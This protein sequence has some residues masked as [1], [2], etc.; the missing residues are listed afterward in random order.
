MDFLLL[1]RV[2][3]RLFF[4]NPR[5]NFEENTILSYTP[6]FRIYLL[7]SKNTVDILQ[8]VYPTKF[9]RVLVYFPASVKWRWEAFFPSLR[10]GGLTQ[11]PSFPPQQNFANT[12]SHQNFQIVFIFHTLQLKSLATNPHIVLACWILS[13]YY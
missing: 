3:L 8:V 9:F 7:T 11:C 4:M 10:F 5:K 12:I 1:W 13:Y 6:C 2:K